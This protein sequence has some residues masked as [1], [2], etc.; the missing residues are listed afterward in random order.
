M[1]ACV[2]QTTARE[3]LTPAELETYDDEAQDVINSI[4]YRHLDAKHPRRTAQP[5]PIDPL[6]GTTRWSPHKGL[7]L[8]GPPQT[9]K[10]T[11]QGTA[12]QRPATRRR[13]VEIKTHPLPLLLGNRRETAHD[14]KDPNVQRRTLIALIAALGTG[15]V[16][17]RA[18]LSQ[19]VAGSPLSHGAV[20]PSD[21]WQ[22]LAL[23]YGQDYL[24]NPRE[25]T[26]RELALDLATLETI[27]PRL[28]STPGIQD[29]L[30]ESGALLAALSESG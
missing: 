20:G 13:T 21:H 29:S 5:A 26:V 11:T 25:Q 15:Q 18:L 22:E 10:T 27:T 3:L 9:P 16:I 12:V 1:L 30:H 6:T 14:A 24:S 23:E 28:S 19:L 2:Y 7:R 17:D 4:D 8:A